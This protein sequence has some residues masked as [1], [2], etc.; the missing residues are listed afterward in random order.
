[1]IQNSPSDMK[2]CFKCGGVKPRSE[3][4]AHP[5]MDDG[6]LGKCKMCARQDSHNHYRAVLSTVST[7]YGNGGVLTCKVCGETK[8]VD[9][10]YFKPTGKKNRRAECADCFNSRHRDADHKNTNA[11]WCTAN[12]DKR[13]ASQCVRTAIRAGALARPLFCS[14]CGEGG[15]IEAHHED[16]TK[17][18][19]I[20]WLCSKCHGRT[21]RKMT[22]RVA[23]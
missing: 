12:K 5:Q 18:L 9:D 4:Y 10:F 17:P 14:C 16:Y 7:R 11:R 21:R 13:R 8:S 20:T 15:K 22:A 19:V 1:M 6:L 3:F 2:R 23:A